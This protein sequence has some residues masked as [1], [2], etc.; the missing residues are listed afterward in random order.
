[1]CVETCTGLSRYIN[2]TSTSGNPDLVRH[3]FITVDDGAVQG[4]E[5]LRKLIFVCG[6][7]RQLGASNS[8]NQKNPHIVM[9]NQRHELRHANYKITPPNGRNYYE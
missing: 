3:R 7:T 5:E 6:V 8:V 2:T 4:D 1:M 9:F